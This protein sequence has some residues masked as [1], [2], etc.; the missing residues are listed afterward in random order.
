MD[1]ESGHSLCD[2]KGLIKPWTCKR[3]RHE[4]C[5]VN[6]TIPPW[7][8]WNPDSAADDAQPGSCERASVGSV[9]TYGDS[10]WAGDADRLSVS[11]I[12]SWLRGKL[13]W[14]PIIASSRKQSTIALGSGEA[15]L[16]AALSGACEGWVCDN[17]GTGYDSSVVMTKCRRMR[18]NRYSA[19][20]PLQHWE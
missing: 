15:E 7:K 5:Q 14:F 3:H 19:V 1:R 11:G 6:F 4:K 16:V 12:A 8:P 18:H 10:D 2:G 9:L 17:S 20:I 13:G